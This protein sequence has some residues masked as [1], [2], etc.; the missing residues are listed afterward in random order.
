ML[1]KEHK[2]MKE[3]HDKHQADMMARITKHSKKPGATS[4]SND[5]GVPIKDIVKEK[6][7]K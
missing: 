6:G 2:A 5:V 7:A 4:G 3:M 1:I